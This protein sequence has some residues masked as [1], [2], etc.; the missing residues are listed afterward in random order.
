M[1]S[2]PEPSPS[3]T[4]AWPAQ[5][6][7]RTK[8][9]V[10]LGMLK[11]RAT[12]TK[13]CRLSSWD[14]NG[15]SSGGT[16]GQWAISTAVRIAQGTKRCRSMLVDRTVMSLILGDLLTVLLDALWKELVNESAPRAC[17]MCRQ[18]IAAEVFHDDEQ[19]ASTM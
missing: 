10:A 12:V 17:T 11:H 2:R 9:L 19:R 13:G 18:S 16:A 3:G 14:R 4:D 7:G 5:W 8:A 1:T 6:S 15:A